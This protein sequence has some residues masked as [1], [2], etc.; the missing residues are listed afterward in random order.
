MKN[1]KLL[2][3]TLSYKLLL[4]TL[5]RKFGHNGR[6]VLTPGD[7]EGIQ[8]FKVTAYNDGANLVIDYD[9]KEYEPTDL[10]PIIPPQPQPEKLRS[11]SEIQGDFWGE[12]DKPS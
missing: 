6:I 8:L 12:N 3:K 11:L 4:A 2:E 10:P 9:R 5:A 7:L 1:E